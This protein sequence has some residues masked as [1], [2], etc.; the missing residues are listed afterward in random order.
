MQSLKYISSRLVLVAS[1]FVIGG[2]A[3]ANAENYPNKPIQIIVPFSAGGVVDL[4]TRAVAQPLSQ[5]YGQPVIVENKTGAGGTIGTGY[6]ANQPADGYTLLSVSPSHAVA[7]SLIKGLTWDPVK[8]FRAILGFGFVPNVFVV[9]PSVPAE[10]M[11]EF[12]DLAK[13][14]ETPLTYGTAGNGTSNHLSGAQLAQ[15]AGIK[16]EQIPYRGQTDA[17]SDLLAGRIDSMPLTITL[18]QQ[19]IANEKLRALAVTPQTRAS[20]LP[21]VPTI[22][23]STTLSDYDVR[24]WFGFVAPKGVPDDVVQKLA[25]D[26]S[27]ILSRDDIKQ[28]LTH[29]GLE[30]QPQSPGEFDTFIASEK[31][32]WGGIMKSEGVQAQ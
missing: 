19:Y 31:Q 4:I 1:L 8:D 6:V 14:S 12:I 24:T 21:D 23:E 16:L 13:K 20:S 28:Q 25:T 22:A 30:I 7:V 27:E 10:T 3:W 26:I 11:A 2:P 18:A 32:K 9:N 29:M 15:M 5:K 17:L